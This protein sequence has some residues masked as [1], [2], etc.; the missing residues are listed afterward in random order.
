MLS[1]FFSQ[2]KLL[3]PLFFLIFSGIVVATLWPFDFS[4]S[5]GVTWIPNRNGIHFSQPAGVLISAS[6]LVVPP[7]A[8][9]NSVTIELWLRSDEIW[10]SRSAVGIYNPAQATPFLIR[11]WNGGLFV[12][13]DETRSPSSTVGDRVYT[14]HLFQRGVP[15]F[16]TIISSPSGTAIYVNA[17]QKQ[18]FPGFQIHAGDLSGQIVLGTAPDSFSPWRGDIYFF[19]LRT[20]AL[21]RDEIRRDYDSLSASSLVLPDPSSVLAQYT[22]T[23]S[24]GSIVHSSLPAASD[25]QIPKDFVLPHKSVLQSPLAHYET[26][27]HYWRDALL[28]II[29]FVPFGLLLCAWLGD[30]HAARHAVLYSFLAGLLFSFLIELVQGYIPQRDSG[31]NDVIT[32]S[33]GTLLGALLFRV[34]NRK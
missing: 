31:F 10:S 34:L 25:L 26:T 33:L 14:K 6:S 5:N 7:S 17:E 21:S 20:T 22:F 28:N 13:R 29:G 9:S 32:N 24:S 4:L 27:W 19:S 3:I 15:L 12:S 23:E 30:T 16:L 11:Q 2:K 18:F 8:A 1:Y